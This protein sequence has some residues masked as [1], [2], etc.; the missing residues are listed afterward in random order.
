MGL[1]TTVSRVVYRVIGFFQGLWTGIKS[2][3]GPAFA[4]LGNAFG[5]LIDAVK[6]LFTSLGLLGGGLAEAA[7]ATNAGTW[8]GFG[9]VI[10]TIA[11]VLVDVFVVAVTMAV[12]VVT[13]LFQ[14]LGWVVDMGRKVL[15]VFSSAGDASTVAMTDPLGLGM[16]AGPDIPGM[17]PDLRASGAAIPGAMA[18]GVAA[19]A[20]KLTAATASM[21]G[22]VGEYMPHSDAQLGPLSTLTASGL[23][24][25]ATLA[26][27]VAAGA[28][29]LTAATENMFGGLGSLADTFNLAPPYF[30]MPSSVM[31][32]EFSSFA[33]QNRALRV[34][35]LADTSEI[36]LPPPS[37]DVQESRETSSPFR[38][39]LDDRDGRKTLNLHIGRIELP[40]VTDAEGFVAGLEAI[41][42]ER[43][44]S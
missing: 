12:E 4:M 38:S 10:G 36:H 6:G 28:P 33:S 5:G 29:A 18:E 24:I 21:M 26:G 25:P 43:M 42:G 32:A 15:S 17:M 34:G 11:G 7:G 31:P 3:T 27:G 23:A 35:S 44:P 13:K 40:A 22:G 9:K 37:F 16:G 39:R 41:I 8:E 19:G 30:E 1:V 20:P 14:A 2:A